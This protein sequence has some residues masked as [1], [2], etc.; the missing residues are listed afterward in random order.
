MIVRVLSTFGSNV[1]AGYTIGIRVVLFALLPAAGLANAAA[2]MVGQALGAG[3]PDRAERSVVIAGWYNCAMLS[4]V[5]A[6]MA[7]FAPAIA[8]LFTQDVQII[9]VASSAL[10]L[11]ALGFPFYGWGMVTSQA[12]NGAGDTKT[13]TWL[14]LF[15]FWLW[16]IPLAWAAKV[17]GFGPTGIFVALAIAFSTYAVAGW[18]VFRRG[19]WKTRRV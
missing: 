13:P 3:K 1:I 15:V 17:L 8:R 6:L 12:L 19:T 4:V 9:P 16:E 18:L 14:N 5:G 10:R 2:T 11:I 7:I